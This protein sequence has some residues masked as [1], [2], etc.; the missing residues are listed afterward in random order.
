MAVLLLQGCTRYEALPLTHDAVEQALVVPDEQALRIQASTL[1]HP[2]IQPIELD[3]VQGYSP[4]EAAVV[5]VI[6]NPD[7]RAQRDRRKLARAQLLSAGILPNPTLNAGL[8]F[9]YNSSPPDDFTAYNIGLDWEVTALLSHDQKVRAASAQA[10][11]VDL[12]VAWQEWQIAQ[13]A[14]IAAY[15][16]IALEDELK[17]AQ[18]ADQQLAENLSIVQSAYDRHQK[19]LLDLSAAQAAA[20]DAH[21]TVL[22]QQKELSHQRLALNRAIGLPPD[23]KF[24]LRRVSL[25]RQLSPPSFDEL[26][27]GFDERRLDLVAFKRG[28]ESQD[29][30]LR[31]AII[32]QFPK[33]TLGLNTARDTSD[34]KTIGVGMSIDIPLFDRNQG[35]I[36]VEKATRQQ[37]FDE[38]ASRVF[39]ARADIASAIDDITSTNAQLDAAQQ[40]IPQLEQFVQ[41]YRDEYQKGN[42]DVLSYWT[43]QSAL[44]Q[45][46]VALVKLTQQ[47]IENWI[48]LE[49]ASGQYLPLTTASTS[50]TKEAAR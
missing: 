23:A 26:T 27:S 24:N 9:P 44:A 37:L 31:A 17:A 21:A 29:A 20:Q 5:A 12:D 15:D 4:E 33:I 42:I 6:V 50:V 43:A 18:E 46:R 2:I 1:K 14:K 36:A 19:T 13:A 32:Q 39:T 22:E 41:T 47:L 49:I 45:K 40:A 25:P 8:D 35:T 16:V 3:A 48:A 30:T 7:L 28:Y 38:Y 11:S 34:V 10:A